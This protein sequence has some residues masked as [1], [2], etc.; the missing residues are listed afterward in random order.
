MSVKWYFAISEISLSRENSDWPGLI[1]A[2]VRSARMNT[3]LK[4]H[5][6]YNGEPN[7]FTNEIANLGVTIVPHR[8]S[9]YDALLSEKEKNPNFDLLSWSGAHLRI[10]IPLIEKQDEIVLYT[11]CDVMFLKDPALPYLP[12]YFAAAPEESRTDYRGINTGV[13]LMNVP[14]LRNDLPAFTAFARQEIAAGR[15]SDQ[16]MYNEFYRD[17]WDRLDIALNW[18]PYWGAEPEAQIVHWHGP[19]PSWVHYYLEFPKYHLRHMSH[20]RRLV[21]M[22][23]DGYRHYLKVW[24]QYGELPSTTPPCIEDIVCTLDAIENGVARGWAFDPDHPDRPLQITAIVDGEAIGH[25]ECTGHRPDLLQA[26]HPTETAGYSISL[27]AR[28]FD[29]RP[30]RLE[31]RSTETGTSIMIGGPGGMALVK[32]FRGRPPT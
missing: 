14:M 12:K 18:K 30:H 3:T 15:P 25:V 23:P 19:K 5:M 17:R 6:L 21:D 31:L 9:F 2:A 4:P 32:E 16:T 29:E 1:R 8:V 24:Q 26:G 22:N 20:W 28:Y 11:D 10:E 13:M 27:P 7:E